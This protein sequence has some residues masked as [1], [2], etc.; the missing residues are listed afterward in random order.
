MKINET[1]MIK[2]RYLIAHILSL[3]NSKLYYL[4][5]QIKLLL[6][7]RDTVVYISLS[8]TNAYM[9][10]IS[11]PGDSTKVERFYVTKKVNTISLP[12]HRMKVERLVLHSFI[13]SYVSH[14]LSLCWKPEL[15]SVVEINNSYL[16]KY[17]HEYFQGFNFTSTTQNE[18]R[19][20]FH[21][22]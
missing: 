5:V 19:D 4:M 21:I 11:S 18:S 16:E 13:L 3:F 2:L 7:C 10:S 20:W 14:V 6:Q 8:V 17:I 12:Q 1:R 15:L 22:P 9:E